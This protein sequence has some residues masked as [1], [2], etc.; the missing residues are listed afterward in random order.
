MP[1][2]VSHPNVVC[3]MPDSDDAYFIFIPHRW[4]MWEVHAAI[5]TNARHRSVAMGKEAAR[6]MRDNTPC[7]CILSFVPKGNYPALVLDRAIGFRRVGVVPKCNPKNG[8]L[9]DMTLMTLSMEN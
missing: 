2:L 7:R 3:L 9:G 1:D 4:M 6:W 5:L 8:T